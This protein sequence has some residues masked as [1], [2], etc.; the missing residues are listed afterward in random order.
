MIEFEIKL[1]ASHDSIRPKLKELGA[2]FIK[3]D[4]NYDQYF[5]HPSK[6]FHNTDEALRIREDVDGWKLTYKGPKLDNKSKS[7]EEL[8]I[9][10]DSEDFSQILLKLDFIRSGTVRKARDL[11]KL[12]QL[13]ISLDDIEGLGEFVEIEI[14]GS[15]EEKEEILLQLYKTAHK[16]GLD[17]KDQIMISYLELVLMKE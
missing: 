10:L 7:R 4:Y 16:L 13:I 8:E 11:W 5:N 9:D 17:P 15:E 2:T 1:R 6:D 14:M 3:S 12:D